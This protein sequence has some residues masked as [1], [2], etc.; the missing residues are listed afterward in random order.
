PE[1][2]RWELIE[3]IAYNMSPSP[4]KS[5][6]RIL[7]ELLRQFANFLFDKKCEIFSAPFDVRIPEPDKGKPD[8]DEDIESVV[9]PDLVVICEKSSLDERGYK[10]IPTLI[11][12]IISPSTASRDM[13]EKFFL[14]ERVGVKEYW[15]VHP[16]EKIVMVFKLGMNRE[17]G[18]PEIYAES[19]KIEVCILGQLT[20]DLKSVF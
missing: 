19:D 5:H 13:K 3:G 17:Y 9:Q 18:K 15:I 1:K 10:G 20:I 2:E 12:E 16:V 14:Y 11:V 4:S 6:Q 8:R 7:R